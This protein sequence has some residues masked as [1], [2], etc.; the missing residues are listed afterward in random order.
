MFLIII[1][2]IV[3]INAKK[4]K[5][6]LTHIAL[7]LLIEYEKLPEDRYLISH[8]VGGWGDIIK[9]SS[10]AFFLALSTQRRFYATFQ[11]HSIYPIFPSLN[12]NN[13]GC[14]MNENVIEIVDTEY[15][16]LDAVWIS[17]ARNNTERC[18]NVHFNGEASY[19]FIHKLDYITNHTY[20]SDLT[21]EDLIWIYMYI[22]VNYPGDNIDKY[23]RYALQNDGSY[24]EVDV[25]VQLRVT[26]NRLNP[27]R[28]LNCFYEKIIHDCG[29][30][31]PCTVFITC[32]NPIITMNLTSMLQ[33]HRYIVPFHSKL[34]SKHIGT[35]K[36]EDD[37]FITIYDW[38]MLSTAKNILISRSGFGETAGWRNKFN[39]DI[40]QSLE[41]NSELC[42]WNDC[43]TR[44]QNIIGWNYC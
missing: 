12:K 13:G 2:L 36:N 6:E 33:K 23:N 22:F 32:D 37:V 31:K 8:P 30:R 25:G 3:I 35:A 40:F 20:L 11:T 24:N 5:Y 41:L 4:T 16:N 21:P 26:E 1:Y 19:Y 7:N 9:G 42:L 34:S 29:K 39:V 28:A 27:Q 18:W 17:K 44:T 43:H 38:W 14:S 10:S 15:D